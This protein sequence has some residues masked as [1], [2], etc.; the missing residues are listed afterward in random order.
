MNQIS[1]ND[2]D[3]SPGLA[4]SGETLSPQEQQV[5][6]NLTEQQL[7]EAQAEL[8]NQARNKGGAL[9]NEN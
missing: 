7:K 4:S 2:I 1:Q 5:L 6:L 9:K 8:E 3:F